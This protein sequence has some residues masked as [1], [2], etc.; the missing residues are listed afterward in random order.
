M[1][2][3]PWPLPSQSSHQVINHHFLEEKSNRIMDDD[4]AVLSWTN[5]YG[6]NNPLISD[7]GLLKTKQV[8][9]G[10]IY[11]P[12][13]ERQCGWLL[14]NTSNIKLQLSCTLNEKMNENERNA[15]LACVKCC[16]EKLY[17]FVLSPKEE[18]FILLEVVAPA[19]VGKYCKFFQLCM[20]NGGYEIGEILEIVCE[21]KGVFGKER[22]KKIEQIVKMGFGERKVIVKTLKMCKWNVGKA[23]DKLVVIGSD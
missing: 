8:I 10:G 17:E 20:V 5:D 22:E 12:G 2:D 19:C 16:P 18:I 23:V 6:S 11:E 13:E 9:G 14:E 15:C 7:P 4:D 21:V 3:C 1:E